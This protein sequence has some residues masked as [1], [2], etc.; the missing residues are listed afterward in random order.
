VFHNEG[1]WDTSNVEFEDGV[2]LAY[3]KKERTPRMK[4][5][6]YGL[7]AFTAKALERVPTDKAFDLAELYGEI[8]SDGELAGMEMK[9]RFY[10]IG[11]PA[12]LEETA[13]FIASQGVA[14]A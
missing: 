9:Q 10:E 8:L 6:D 1:Q 2:I 3:D 14:K 4:F 7:G 13:R 11:S 5:I 12:G